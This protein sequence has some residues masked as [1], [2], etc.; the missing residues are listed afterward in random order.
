MDKIMQY[1]QAHAS[2]LQCMATQMGNVEARLQHME[3]LSKRFSAKLESEALVEDHDAVRLRSELDDHRTAPHKLIRYWPSIRPILQ[4]AGVNYSDNYVRDLEDR[5]MLSLYTPGG[6]DDYATRSSSR[7]RT[8]TSDADVCESPVTYS[9]PQTVLSPV[10]G[11]L[12]PDDSL[13]LDVETINMLYES[14]VKHIHIMHPFIDVRK[15]RRMVECFVGVH[16]TSTQ[17]AGAASPEMQ[18]SHDSTNPLKRKRNDRPAESRMPT[19]PHASFRN[20]A[21]GRQAQHAVVYLVLALGKACLHK[22][23]ISGVWHDTAMDNGMNF[24]S[25]APTRKHSTASVMTEQISPTI[26][27]SSVKQGLQG[28]LSTPL[29]ELPIRH[30][31]VTST[32]SVASANVHRLPG[33]AYYAKAAVILGEQ[34]DGND[35]IHAQ[36][37]LLAGLYK[38]QLARVVE[39]MSWITRASRVAMTLLER[40]QLYTDYWTAHGDIRKKL[41]RGQARITSKNANL[42]VLVSWSCLQLESDILADIRLPSSGIQSIENSLLMPHNS[43]EDG[44][45]VHEQFPRHENQDEYD[46]I[47]IYYTAQLFLRR[48]LN[49]IHREMYGS[50]CLSQPLEQVRETLGGYE[51]LLHSWRG[52]LPGGYKWDDKEKPAES[53]LAAR[54]RAKYYGMSHLHASYPLLLLL[55]SD[56]SSPTSFTL[57]PVVHL[58]ARYLVN[59]PF[60]DYALHIMPAIKDGRTVRE[61]ARDVIG[62]PRHEADIHIFEAIQGMSEPG[63]L[64]ACRR[65]IEAAI[66]STIAFDGVPEHDLIVTNIHG[67]AHAQFGNMLVLS[68]AYYSKN[69]NPMVPPDHFKTLLERTVAFL[70]RVASISPTCKVDSEILEEL[71]WR[72]FGVAHR[73]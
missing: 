39:S 24:S 33:L 58:C 38:G 55:T 34:G 46:N 19:P 42:V 20:K 53:L 61:A 41:A 32:M 63:I 8:P 13:Q 64:R 23:A 67:T 35:L 48:K 29:T 69:L 49:Q 54:L 28:H 25:T 43:Q 6:V 10:W 27:F 71:H 21:K 73:T 72:S 52:S 47:L 15:L 2:G 16:G 1:M 30:P 3:E 18:A 9:E 26:S 31:S 56:Y 36:M 7:S 12:R 50:D 66:Q 57:E 14:Y 37:F 59:R 68:A 60:L 17:D 45:G 40:Y 22:H 70:R 65:C 5:S 62:E 11:D 51:L 44:D 4:A